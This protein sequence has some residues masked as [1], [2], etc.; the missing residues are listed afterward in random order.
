M[1]FTRRFILF[2]FS[3][4]FCSLLSA[5]N[6]LDVNY[7]SAATVPDFINVCGDEDEVQVTVS[8]VGFS[9]ALRSDINL[10]IEL[11]SGISLTSFSAA[12]STAGVVLTDNSNPNQPVFSIPDLSP[13][14]LSSVNISFNINAD[15]DYTTAL[16]NEN[17][18]QVFD[19]YNFNYTLGNQ[20]NINE[21]DFT[22]EYRDAFAVPFFT[23]EVIND[24]PSA[25][26]GDC[27]ERDV[28]ITN[29]SING[30]VENLTYANLQSEG[31]YVEEL[32]FNNQSI[33][34]T[35][36]L[37][38]TGD[39]LITA[40]I[41]SSIFQNIGNNDA[42]FN[43]NENI[44]I[45]E[46]YCLV[47][48]IAGAFS[49][50]TVGWGCNEEICSEVFDVDFVTMGEGGANASII[51]L[52]NSEEGLS[53][54]CQMGEKTLTFTNNGFEIDAGFGTMRDVVAGIGLGNTF[55]L[56]DNAYII[57]DYNLAGIQITDNQALITLDNHPLFT[58]DPDGIGG[59][60]DMDGDGFFDD[61]PLGESFQ[62]KVNY[63]FDCSN[64]AIDTEFTEGCTNDFTTSLNGRISWKNNCNETENRSLIAFIRPAN[65]NSDIL[66]F[67]ETD[68]FA[69]EDI[70][71]VTHT[72]SRTVRDFAFNCSD[73]R[74]T[75]RVA[76]PTGVQPEIAE[77][78]LLKN[79]VNEINLIS[80][81][82]SNDTFILV[83]DAGN[84][85]FLNGD[86][87]LDLAFSASCDTPLGATTFP[88]TFE[89]SC[90]DCDCQHL[91]YC[92][93]LN[94]PQ[95]HNRMPPCT[96]AQTLNCPEG[97]QTTD[98]QANRTSFGFTDN[99]YTAAINPSEANHKVAI[100]C[101]MV[102]L[103][104]KNIVGATAL[105]D[106]IGVN[107]FYTNP[108]NSTEDI[109]LFNYVSGEV[110]FVKNGVETSC[111]IATNQLSTSQDIADKTVTIDLSDCL[112]SLNLT[113]TEG[114]SVNFIGQFSLNPDGPLSSQFELIP[115][116]RAEGFAMIN[117]N[118]TAC[119][120]Y[121]ENF[122]V[123]TTQTVFDFPNNDNFPIGCEPRRLQYRLIT[124]NN[125]FSDFFGD[126]FRPAIQ[127]DSLV[128]D[129]DPNILEAF[130]DGSVEVSIPG[131]PIHGE[132]FYFIAPLADFSNGHYVAL[133]DTLQF[134]PSL[135]EVQSYAFNLRVNLMPTCESLTG[136]MNGDADYNF[137]PT[138]Y[139]Q[140][141]IHAIDNSMNGCPEAIAETIQSNLQYADAPMLS[142]T[143]DSPLNHILTG[144]TATW[145]VQLC[146]ISPDADAATTWLAAEDFSGIV[147][148]LSM[149]DVTDPAN[150]VNFG[151]QN[152]G[153]DN[154]F[155]F[156]ETGMLFRADGLN[157]IEQ[158]C[159]KVRIKAE[160]N[161]CQNATFSLRAGYNCDDFPI[162]WTP[163]DNDACVEED[164]SLSVT[165]RNPFLEAEVVEQSTSPQDIC[166]EHTF[167]ILLRNNDQGAAFDVLTNIILPPTGVVLVP[168][169]FKV[170]YPS[171]APYA[172]IP[173]P[174]F[175][176]ATIQG[177]RYYYPD[178]SMISALLNENG[179]SGFD[180]NN[181]TSNNEMLLRFSVETDCGFRNGDLISYNFQGEKACGDLTN[182]EAGET[183]PI[184]INGTQDI[185]NQLF[186][187]EFTTESAVIPN[188]N[189]TI[190]VNLTNLSANPSTDDDII[191]VTLPLGIQY[192][193]G[194]TSALAPA[195]WELEGPNIVIEDDLQILHWVMIDGL[196][197]N[198]TASFTFGISA[199]NF[200]CEV[201]TTDFRLVTL[202]QNSVFCIESQENCT[203]ESITSTNGGSLINLPANGN[204]SVIFTNS[205]ATC[206]NEESEE[207]L[208]G[209]Q[210]VT[211]SAAFAQQD[212]ELDVYFD[213][214][215]N[216]L[217]DEDEVLVHQVTINGTV[218]IDNALPFVFTFNAP[219]N[220]VCHLI[221]RLA[222]EDEEFCGET[223]NIIS[224]PR[225]L[226]A[227]DNR[228]FCASENTEITTELGID[229]PV[230]G[231][232]SYN[233]FA[234]PPASTGDLSAINIAQP[235]L[236]IIHTGDIQPDLQ[237]VLETTR[238]DCQSVYDTVT[239]VRSVNPIISTPATVQIAPTT[240]TTLIPIILG[241]VMPFTYEW[242]PIGSLNNS[243]V[244][245]PTASPSESVDYTLSLT[246]SNG[247]TTIAIFPVVVANPIDAQI[248]PGNINLCENETL[249]LVASGGDTYLWEANP[250]NIGGNL[251]TTNGTTTVFGGGEAGNDYT[252]SVIVS[253]EE[254]PEFTDTATITITVII[255]PIVTAGTDITICQGEQTLITAVVEASSDAIIS[256]SPAVDFG[257][258]ANESL[259][260]P[261]ITTDYTITV[262]EE[263][264][265]IS[266][267]IIRVNVEDCSCNPAEVTGIS[268]QNSTC[269]NSEGAITISTELAPEN[270]NFIWSTALGTTN[271]AGNVRFNLPFGGYSIRIENT[272]DTECFE[273]VFVSIENEDGPL[274]TAHSTN[275]T[276]ELAN[277]TATL[278]PTGFEYQWEDAFVGNERTDLA[279]NSYSVTAIDPTNPLC[280]NVL[281]IIIGQDNPLSTTIEV[282]N[283]PICGAADGSV[284]LTVTGGSG[285][286]T[287]SWL[288]DTNVQE[289]IG[290]GIY[291]VTITDADNGC[292]LPFTF[293]LDDAVPNGNL[294][295]NEITDVTCFGDTDGALSFNINPDSGFDMAVDTV[296]SN[297][298]QEFENGSLPAGDYCLQLIN[299]DGCASGSLCFTVNSPD[300]LK[301]DLS[302]TAACEEGGTITT[303]ISGGTMPYTYLW[304]DFTTTMNRENLLP[305]NYSLTVTDVNDCATVATT[306]ILDCNCEVPV[307]ES[308][309][310]TPSTCGDATGVATITI[311][312][313]IND[314]TYTWVP[315]TG[316]PNALG[317]TRTGLPAGNYSIIVS[318]VDS[319]TCF[320]QTSVLIPNGD[321][322]AIQIEVTAAFCDD[323][324]GTATL[325]PSTY[326]Y[327][328]EGDLEDASTQTGLASGTYMVTVTEPTVPGCPNIFQVTIPESN[329][330]TAEVT[331]NQQPICQQANGIATIEVEGGSGNYGYSWP[332][333]AATQD[334]LFAGLYSVTITDLNSS[335]CQLPI[336]FVLTDQIPQAEII[337]NSINNVN[338]AG[339]SDGEIF[340]E[341]T[342]QDGFIAPLQTVISNG[343]QDFENGELPEGS[344]CIVLRDG[345]DCVAGG[346]CF[347][348]TEPE[349]LFVAGTSTESC[350]N[351]GTINLTVSGG[352]SP[353]NFE[354][355]DSES[356]TEDRIGLIPGTF[357]PTITDDNGCFI[358]TQI[359][360]DTCDTCEIFSMDSLTIQTM[361]CA[362][363]HFFCTDLTVEI[364]S[365]YII[366][367]NEIPLTDLDFCEGSD[368]NF[369]LELA[370]GSHFLVA[371]NTIT[372][373]TDTLIANILCI[374]NDTL[375]IDIYQYEDSLL[376]F[377]TEELFT[378]FDTLIN[379]CPDGQFVDYNLQND[380]CLV[381]TANEIGSETAC[382]IVCDTLG[383]CDTTIVNI[384]VLDNNPAAIIDTII[385]TQTGTIC[386]DT[387]ATSLQGE[388]FSITNLCPGESGQFLDYQLN[389]ETFCV[390]Y[391]GVAL[392]TDNA[393]IQICD[394]FNNCDT[395]NIS[396]TVVPGEFFYD[397]LFIS[398]NPDTLCIDTTLLAGEIVS[399]TDACP[400]LNGVNVDFLYLEDSYCV[401]YT[402]LLA[403]LDT[404]CVRL[405]DEYG[406]I[407]LINMVIT[408]IET[409]PEYIVDTIFIAGS[410]TVCLNTDELLAGIDF[411]DDACAD[412][413]TGTVDFFFNPVTNCVEYTGL[414]IGKDTACYFI[415][416][417]IGICDTTYFCILVEEYFDPPVANP[418]IDTTN[419]GTPIV[420]DIKQNDIIFGGITESS[421][422][423]PPQYGTAIINPDCSVTYLPDPE[424]CERTDN[425]SY[426]ICN[427]NGCSITT[428][429]IFIACL[430]IRVFN[431]ISPNGDG[432]NDEFYIANIEG[433]PSNLEIYNRWGNLVFKTKDYANKWPGTYD[434]E[435][436]LPDGTYYYLLEWADPD[437]GEEFFQRG[438]VELRR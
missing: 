141:H 264:G 89:F 344:Y 73:A 176:D 11:F 25:R 115:N 103:S 419:R 2:F 369:T 35:K 371:E 20:A 146:N 212:F 360:V 31:V 17:Q 171:D 127:M 393:C 320:T 289:N 297:G 352:T 188:A 193:I 152:Y 313:D 227:G 257:Q 305:G 278:L 49:S 237:Y 105:N 54:Y 140:D 432:K 391:E 232:Y 201:S 163:A 164:L 259:V 379:L 299:S 195:N 124:V 93:E 37:Q 44:T 300:I 244:V 293:S 219:V 26:V 40:E 394:A 216:G 150:P 123:A 372:G 395:L 251:S 190:G 337:V 28:F 139:Y 301:A 65:N 374:L 258:N 104:V 252:Y 239:I 67:T 350:G 434:T 420:I 336:L 12:N 427:E 236:N 256:W 412:S 254:F 333:N 5:Q 270:Y 186:G 334:E 330:L 197:Q 202:S 111:P 6:N 119:D 285:N 226:N 410:D 87:R 82:I 149:E 310:S 400:E 98:F 8:T 100:S 362:E 187:I 138:I 234:I 220:Q 118:Q 318:H 113:L 136:S 19:T 53:G 245:N 107:I 194:S 295:I 61:L 109:D 205:L 42:A 137:S 66:N 243:T 209:G 74:F 403:G 30:S 390:N 15:C 384:N 165:L 185:D 213:A 24:S 288:S 41:S 269:G 355:A 248:T 92:G 225:F 51:P 424:Y 221:T 167:S 45:T 262:T 436:D 114:D 60:S 90:A 287:Y 283:A 411:I 358:T 386:F 91:W 83:Y 303:S 228:A 34:F 29:S 265:C 291:I 131:H 21:T 99:T 296:I 147:N 376:C 381:I 378:E 431:V 267:D 130:T 1:R 191:T 423:T 178:F 425:F 204:L 77:T 242:S 275:A 79:E 435:K 338:C 32:S 166:T 339:G 180:P 56:S 319:P 207:I 284:S 246:D 402:P 430:D 9:S 168:N 340:Y 39:T 280:P 46:K 161:T 189:S 240:S 397:T 96:A 106:N 353:Y 160:V 290:S 396:M 134:R 415:C 375:S 325:M 253:N 421:I 329:P 304:N 429:E 184:V 143:P 71:V 409:T 324:N 417:S 364:S 183:L 426:E 70:F 408:V 192:I 272:D 302:T 102:E 174:V 328:W 365:F 4:C 370:V 128:F 23:I 182:F 206:A 229:C 407:I 177:E 157:T 331:V 367:D 36:T 81:S 438:F 351:D 133:F 405:E 120:N 33:P 159:R 388:F 84:S 198:E 222:S 271:L 175:G 281:T 230:I 55:T 13:S 404:T 414:D 117:G 359:T 16:S 274:T 382:I 170:A 392:G 276:C 309:V 211:S 294:T 322:P 314:F 380:T 377:N 68:A 316:T 200:D 88:L 43:P 341:V 348:I 210:I 214:N 241:G 95:L 172:S 347:D 282:L 86:Y 179:L 27:V 321:G 144:D 343:I 332:S 437:T 368:S 231:V 317:N 398:A 223:Q 385:V 85:P 155:I 387:L 108:N 135:N 263:N 224:T 7:S 196:A 22:S 349:P 345:N 47:S 3:F 335:N 125:G 80:Q 126:E 361:A 69:E 433:K 156:T 268:V 129:F 255:A 72:Q 110:I 354:W 63:E 173:N 418:D 308:I 399:I 315:E 383:I 112:T 416:D 208:V 38:I 311:E 356:T 413:T 199:N 132:D 312:G 406:N 59:L 94:G 203:I 148:L 373:C 62:I 292:V 307:V 215:Q 327:D 78:R 326:T 75:A 286:Y 142:L 422:T 306:T 10:T 279:A 428:V 363:N 145:A 64:A 261:S 169:S 233:W 266:T 366:T 101:D 162:D 389:E 235:T 116:F 158:I 346:F 277:G 153:Q 122:T 48:C 76:L 260:S 58:S 52:Q 97:L 323:A 57:T 250:T 357:M 121:G 217:I 238:N 18:V 249:E 181:P 342:T 218:S 154:N 247:C 151:I 401:V 14:S 273:E 50:H 298:L